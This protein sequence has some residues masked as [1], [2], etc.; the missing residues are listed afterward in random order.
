MKRKENSGKRLTNLLCIFSSEKAAAFLFPVRGTR[1]NSNQCKRR[2]CAGRD[3]ASR[4][5][6]SPI[7]NQF[8]V[9]GAEM[10]VRFGG[11]QNG[12]FPIRWVSSTAHGVEL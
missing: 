10:R 11:L 4:S 1:T 6:S 8:L 9:N 12:H 2:R 3:E 7:R 5:E